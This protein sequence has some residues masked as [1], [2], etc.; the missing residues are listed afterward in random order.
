MRWLAV[1]AH[2]RE[3][4]VLAGL[5]ALVT[6]G[7]GARVWLLVATGLPV[8]FVN[9]ALVM[10]SLGVFGLLPLGPSASPAGTLATLGASGTAG[11][12]SALVLGIVVSATS[13]C[14][15]GVYA[16]VAGAAVLA[17]RAPR[18]RRPLTSRA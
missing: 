15:V 11:V 17:E 18:A 10:L 2:A 1:L 6:A 5:V 16:I 4:V 13:I 8:T 14:G 3:R 7:G 12:G 9:V